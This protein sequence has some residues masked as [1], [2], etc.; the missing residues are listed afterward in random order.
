MTIVG[1]GELSRIA[2]VSRNFSSALIFAVL[3]SV[4]SMKVV[5]NPVTAPC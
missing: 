4:V 3:R 5:I 1:A 2:L